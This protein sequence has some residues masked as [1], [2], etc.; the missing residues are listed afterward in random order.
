MPPLVISS[1]ADLELVRHT[2]HLQDLVDSALE[3]AADARESEQKA[4]A[5][6]AT[7]QREVTFWRAV[8]IIAIGCGLTLAA[9]VVW[10][11]VR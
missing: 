10:L 8:S 2:K 1:Q 7:T 6:L 3:D 4:L 5:Y 9:A 11:E